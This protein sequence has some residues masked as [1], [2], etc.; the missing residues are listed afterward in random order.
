MLWKSAAPVSDAKQR[1]VTQ[2]S[3]AMP[4]AEADA[5]AGIL[6]LAHVL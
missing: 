5:C 3:T 2:L 1:V 4:G 6:E